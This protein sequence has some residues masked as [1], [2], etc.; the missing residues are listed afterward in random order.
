M[1][2][3]PYCKAW[4][5]PWV[6]GSDGESHT[7]RTDADAFNISSFMSMYP[8]NDPFH[9]DLNELSA[10]PSHETSVRRDDTIKCEWKGCT[11]TGLFARK[12]E[13]K[14]HVETQHISPSSH[15]C[16]E[17]TCMR[18]FNRRDNLDEHLRRTHF[19]RH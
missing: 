13:L 15:E 18:T 12:A 1:S 9:L 3:N 17:P 8:E 10:Q 7:F 16:P 14:R 11:Y 2:S 19:Q 4:A 6:N 5:G